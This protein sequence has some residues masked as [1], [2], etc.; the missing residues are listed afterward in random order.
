MYISYEAACEMTGLKNFHCRRS[1][2][3]LNYGLKAVQH[4]QNK[5]NFPLK[6]VES[7]LLLRKR[8]KFHVNFARTEAYKQSAVPSIQRMLNAHDEGRTKDKEER[9]QGG[10]DLLNLD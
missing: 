3:S 6:E 8:E 2:R 9:G 4:N 5:Q 10:G 1:E 7:L